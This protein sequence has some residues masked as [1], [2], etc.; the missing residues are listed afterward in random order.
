MTNIK[1]ALN[2]AHTRY[3]AHSPHLKFRGRYPAGRITHRR[4]GTK[5]SSPSQ[6]HRELGLKRGGKSYAC[7]PNSAYI[8]ENSYYVTD[9]AGRVEYVFGL[10]V[11]NSKADRHLYQQSRVGK[12]AGKGYHGGHLIRSANGGSGQAI[13]MVPMAAAINATNGT[14][15]R[16]EAELANDL[17]KMSTPL[18]VEISIS[19]P[20][21]SSLVP[22]SF[23]VNAYANGINAPPHK[24]FAIPNC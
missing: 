19:Y 17:S 22:A 3:I 1:A 4:S 18:A 13:N 15:G 6:W 8:V 24:T 7:H 10:Y 2:A 9:E 16:M 20:D 21:S 14:W 5:R 12:L 11:K 23:S